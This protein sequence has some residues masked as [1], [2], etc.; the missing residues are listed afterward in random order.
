[1]ILILGL[2]LDLIQIIGFGCR[3][4]DEEKLK[5]GLLLK[6]RMLPDPV[7]VLFAAKLYI[8]VTTQNL[9]HHHQIM[10]ILYFK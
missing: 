4:S 7:L 5:L 8:I 1:M 9:N 3:S 6:L 10:E 2:V